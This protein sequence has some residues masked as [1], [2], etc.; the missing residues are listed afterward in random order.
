MR[1]LISGLIVLDLNG[2][3]TSLFYDST[4]IKIVTAFKVCLSSTEWFYLG[5]TFQLFVY[6]THYTIIH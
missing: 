1:V 4:D 2:T 6:W 5:T 3:A